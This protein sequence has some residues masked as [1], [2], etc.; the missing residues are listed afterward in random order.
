MKKLLLSIL[1]ILIFGSSLLAQTIVG[2]DPENKNVVMEEFTGLNCPNCPQGHAIAEAIYTANPD[3]VVLVNVHVGSFATPSGSQPDYRTPWGGA[4]DAQAQVAGYP[5]GTVNRHLFAGW[6]QSGGTAMS[7]NYWEGAANIVLG[8]SSYLNVGAEATIITS[9]RQLVVN[10][11]VY[12]T[13]DSPASSNFLTVAMMQSNIYGYQSGGSSNYNHK[14]MLRHFLTGQWGYEITET[15]EG[16]LYT[17]SLYYEIPEDY[18]DVACVLED[19][20]IAAYVAESHQEIIS[21]NYAE[22]TLVEALDLDAGIIDYTVP[23]TNCGEQ[24]NASVTIKN[25]GTNELTSLD[26]EY[27]VNN[28]EVQT[29][30]WTGSLAQNETEVIELPAF[31]IE[32]NQSNTFSL[33]SLNPNNQTDEL[34]ANNNLTTT[35]EKTAFLPQNCKVAILTDVNP[36]ETTW[37][38][39]NSAGEVIASG[40]PYEV[41]SI[42][43]E[44]FVWPANDCYTFT[45]YDAG[46]DGMSSG[47]YKIVNS[48]NQPIWEGDIDFGSM[49]NAEFAFDE[50]MGIETSLLNEE[51]SVYPNPVVNAAQ[52]DFSLL[53]QSTVQLGI[54]N[55]LGKRIIQIYSGNL[56]LG[57]HKFDIESQ[58]LENGVYFVKLNIDGEEST[59]KI[60]IVK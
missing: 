48:S 24:M 30:T 21:G 3:D 12:Y 43:I 33:T 19:L 58:D 35:F 31:E 40:G 56:P 27:A 17:A 20:E 1:T 16:S 36:Q 4:L 59:Q 53:Q 51:F 10:V 50:V 60:Q 49:A 15:T 8:E 13:G 29:Y 41:S 57:Q 44:P 26:F 9:T 45:M 39:K 11:E 2:T 32:A 38:I 42:Y 6:G 18:N 52:V 14:H 37:D 22:L 23:Q 5:A 55:I 46:G 47:F 34:P 25:F 28:G 54:Y 7:R